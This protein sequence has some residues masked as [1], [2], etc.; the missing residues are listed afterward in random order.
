MDFPGR[1]KGVWIEL[2]KGPC[3]HW[4]TPSFCPHRSN[5]TEESPQLYPYPDPSHRQVV[6]RVQTEARAKS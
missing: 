6:G 4:V 3:P 1:L 2:E 5:E